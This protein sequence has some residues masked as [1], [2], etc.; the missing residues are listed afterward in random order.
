M[1]YLA[2]MIFNREVLHW[3]GHMGHARFTL[4]LHDYILSTNPTLIFRCCNDNFIKFYD[5]Y[6][7][8][9]DINYL[10]NRSS[11]TISEARGGALPYMTMT[12]M[13]GEKGPL[14]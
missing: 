10:Q 11:H 2:Q 4:Y 3:C 1:A 9:N 14:F 6:T 8:T 12:G 7:H 13:L 5:V